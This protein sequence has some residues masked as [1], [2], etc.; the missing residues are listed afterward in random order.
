MIL[1]TDNPKTAREVN[2]PFQSFITIT[3]SLVNSSSVE[4]AEVS[5]KSVTVFFLALKSNY[6]H[7]LNVLQADTKNNS[8]M[9]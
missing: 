2:Y 3:V 5:I 6:D 1:I 9:F 7:I 8:K 4:L